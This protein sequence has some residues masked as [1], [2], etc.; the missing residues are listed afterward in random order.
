MCAY[1]PR[2]PVFRGI[3]RTGSV[4]HDGGVDREVSVGRIRVA[5]RGN[6]AFGEGV[7]SGGH[8]GIAERRVAVTPFVS[9]SPVVEI[10]VADGGVA[11]FGLQCGVQEHN[12]D[13]PG[14]RRISHAVVDVQ[15]GHAGEAHQPEIIVEQVVERIVI[16][17]EVQVRVLSASPS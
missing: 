15:P 10:V 17:V 5:E 2:S 7:R 16:E 3:V 4:G 14:Q 1:S 11:D 8:S 6:I 13:I 12:R 9:S